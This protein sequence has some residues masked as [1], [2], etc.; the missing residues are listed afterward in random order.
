MSSVGNRSETGDLE[1]LRRENRRLKDDVNYLN[2][3]CE[4]LMGGQ[5]N[6]DAMVALLK[7]KINALELLLEENEKDYEAQIHTLKKK[8]NE[9]QK[10]SNGL[11][12]T[13]REME[14]VGG[15]G[16]GRRAELLDKKLGE[17]EELLRLAG[18]Q[19][20]DLQLRV[21]E[22][23]NI[24]VEPQEAGSETSSRDGRK[25][26]RK[27]PTKLPSR[28]TSREDRRLPEVTEK[29]VRGTQGEEELKRMVGQVLDEK[30]R[31]EKINTELT[32][33]IMVLM[34]TFEDEKAGELKRERKK[35]EQQTISLKKELEDTKRQ[36]EDN[37]KNLFAKIF[38]LEKKLNEREEQMRILGS[39]IESLKK[40]LHIREDPSHSSVEVVRYL[41]KFA[42]YQNQ[43]LQHEVTR[44][45]EDFTKLKLDVRRREEDANALKN[46][47]VGLG[48]EFQKLKNELELK[49]ELLAIKEEEIKN[50]K[51]ENNNLVV[52]MEL[53]RREKV[54]VNNIK[55]ANN[56]LSNQLIHYKALVRRLT[57]AHAANA[58]NVSLGG[59]FAADPNASLAAGLKPADAS[60]NPQL[61]RGDPD[62]YGFKELKKQFEDAVID[63]TR[64]QV[65]QKVRAPYAD[66]Q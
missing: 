51:Q 54:Q 50:L 3:K 37:E 20:R 29:L 47:N 22:L 2:K 46:K 58:A 26:I 41:E 31:L 49:S 15:G 39:G 45:Q 36:K 14:Q 8:Y 25:F 35:F 33:K 40:E 7:N 65:I 1:S 32:N 12:N 11:R 18:L 63:G 27:R 55:K 60:S 38:G 23:L 48:H 43:F 17:K 42:K 34:K 28:S 21:N 59:A 62:A 9:L 53:L 52:A 66:Q 5:N 6:D 13:I 24:E 10:E 56:E 16:D 4:E 44:F 19:I 61:A 30:G 57:S 64:I